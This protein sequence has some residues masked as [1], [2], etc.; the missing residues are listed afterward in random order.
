MAKKNISE[1][2]KLAWENL[3]KNSNLQRKIVDGISPQVPADFKSTDYDTIRIDTELTSISWDN[4]E[5]II[6]DNI[7]DWEKE[8]ECVP[9]NEKFLEGCQEEIEKYFEKI[10]VDDKE[11]PVFERCAWYNS[12]HFGAVDWGMHIKED[13]WLEIAKTIYKGDPSCRSKSAAVKSAFLKV[14]LHELYHHFTDNSA[15]VMELITKDPD[16]Y[17]RYY[18]NVYRK[19]VK[20]MDKGSL[21]ESLANRYLAG[22]F[23]FCK[24]NKHFLNCYLERQSIG[25]RHFV[26]YKGSKFRKGR[27]KLLNQ[28]L[29]SVSPP[30]H[31][32]PIEQIY[33]LLDQHSYSSGTRMPIY[34]HYKKGGK[35][36]IIL[37]GRI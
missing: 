2:L 29:E 24:I 28:I 35:K 10:P 17:I 5:V 23:D 26:D 31:D 11:T 30:I 16:I 7:D 22:R 9:E 33:D 4:I 15:T 20:K 27:R 13:C 6:T 25:Y 37:K 36:R 12:Y 19:D 34:I 8:L 1:E 18:Y 14:F 32:I 3:S 21:E